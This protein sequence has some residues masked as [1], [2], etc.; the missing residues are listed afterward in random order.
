MDHVTS[1]RKFTLIALGLATGGLTIA[2][3]ASPA[4]AFKVNVPGGESNEGAESPEN[5][6]PE[7]GG[8]QSRHR[9][10]K[11]KKN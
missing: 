1:R 6:N 5:E 8:H 10:R 2:T 11:H 4:M 7:G 9:R 3:V